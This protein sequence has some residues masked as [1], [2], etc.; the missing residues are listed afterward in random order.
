MRKD[1]VGHA[2]DIF[3]EQ[4]AQHLG[5]RRFHQRREAGD[6]G[7]D[8]RDIA[9]VYLHAVAIGAGGKPCGNLR[10]KIPRKRRMRALGLGLAAP[11]FAQCLDVAHGLVDG[12]FK[13]AK[14]DRLGQEIERATIHRGADIA[15]VAIGRN[16]DGRFLVFGLLQLLQQGQAVHPRHIDVG[17]HHVDMRILLNRGQ[18]LQSVMGK[19]EGHRAVANLLAEFLQDESLKIGLIIDD[20]DGCGHAACS[21][22]VSISWRSNAKSIGLVNSPTAPRSIALRRVSASP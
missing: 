10:R 5:R 17:H 8:G 11:S 13:I 19:H 18:R 22:R 12:G 20:E 1:H 15:H 21:T 14:I 4:R 7:E 9:P 16:D 2:A 3:V 6:V